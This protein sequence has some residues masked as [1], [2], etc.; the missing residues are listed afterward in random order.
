M[1]ETQHQYAQ[2][3]K[4]AL[5][6]AWA[7]EKFADFIVGKHIE[8]ETYHKPVVLFLGCK[9]LDCL[10]PYILKFHLQLDRFR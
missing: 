3:E 9:G 8:I 1:S 7:C 10:P 6:T 2:M 4:E 5:T